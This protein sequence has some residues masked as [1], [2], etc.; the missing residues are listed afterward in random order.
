MEERERALMFVRNEEIEKIT[1]G[2]EGVWYKY[3]PYDP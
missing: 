2:D 1:V 3:H